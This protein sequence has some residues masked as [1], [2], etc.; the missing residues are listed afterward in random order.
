MLGLSQLWSLVPARAGREP[1]GQA[2]LAA[3]IGSTWCR[4]LLPPS[5][6]H[7]EGAREHVWL[8]VQVCT[9]TL[10]RVKGWL[11]GWQGRRKRGQVPG[12]AQGRALG[13]GQAAG[14]EGHGHPEH[15]Y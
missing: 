7:G 14:Q 10:C 4:V 15:H 6:C 8:G 2:L 1:L 12:W 3:G 13:A 11:C 9:E 5:P